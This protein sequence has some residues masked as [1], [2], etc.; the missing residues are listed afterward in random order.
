MEE[1]EE[2]EVRVESISSRPE[3]EH[4]TGPRISAAGV[5]GGGRIVTS[6][7]WVVSVGRGAPA[8]A[9]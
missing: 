7:T 4:G 1:V 6:V 8:G 9:Q 5:G 2:E 3:P